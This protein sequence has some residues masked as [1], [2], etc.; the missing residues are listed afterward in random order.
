MR[1]GPPA[2]SPPRRLSAPPGGPWRVSPRTGK[3]PVPGAFPA[4]RRG[5]EDGPVF[6]FHG[7]PTAGKIC[8][9][10]PGPGHGTESSP[11][12]PHRQ[13]PSHI[14]PPAPH[15]PV[16]P[17]HTPGNPSLRRKPDSRKPLPECPLPDGRRIPPAQSPPPKAAPPGWPPGFRNRRSCPAHPATSPACT[18]A[19][20]SPPAP[21]Q[22][23]PFRPPPTHPH[24]HTESAP[25]DWPRNTP[26]SPPRLPGPSCPSLR[27][28]PRSP[29]QNPPSVPAALPP[30]QPPIP[31][32]PSASPAAA[33]CSACP[34]CF[35]ASVLPA[36]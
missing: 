29:P 35:P 8:P 10:L 7:Q 16:R 12:V 9:A 5:R 33:V 21:R 26:L 6:V 1:A 27:R 36:L 32:T 20:A 14:P 13:R 18:R 34:P 24:P 28:T 11:H 3:A 4:F 2:R 25:V 17:F 15:R 22:R 30:A 19:G 23:G 31:R